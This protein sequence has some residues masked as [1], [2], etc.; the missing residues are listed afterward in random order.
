MSIVEPVEEDHTL[1]SAPGLHVIDVFPAVVREPGTK[2]GHGDLPRAHQID[3]HREAGILDDHTS[4]KGAR[5]GVL[6][7]ASKKGEDVILMFI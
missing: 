7:E 2:K 5:L 6:V 4:E 3:A 1:A